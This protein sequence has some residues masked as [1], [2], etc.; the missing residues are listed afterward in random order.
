MNKTTETTIGIESCNQKDTQ[1]E[2]KK[3]KAL[4]TP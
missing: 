1:L 3:A 2:F 4:R